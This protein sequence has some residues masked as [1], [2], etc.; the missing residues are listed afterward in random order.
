M[1]L[2]LGNDV[3]VVDRH[4]RSVPGKDLCVASIWPGALINC[5]D[6]RRG[7]F[8]ELGSFLDVGL[9]AGVL[10]CVIKGREEIRLD[11]TSAIQVQGFAGRVLQMFVGWTGGHC[12][13]N[14]Q[15]Q[16]KHDCFVHP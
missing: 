11:H 15:G 2:V 12:I 5:S 14:E 4:Q 10:E 7:A 3:T 8:L 13:Q 16:E 9:H 6:H 1:R